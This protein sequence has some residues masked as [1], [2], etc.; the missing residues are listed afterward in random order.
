MSIKNFLYSAFLLLQSVNVA[1]Q[2]NAQ[3]S[4]LATA[5]NPIILTGIPDSGNLHPHQVNKT[6]L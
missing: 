1:A 4:A 3:D 5:S 6:R 2:T